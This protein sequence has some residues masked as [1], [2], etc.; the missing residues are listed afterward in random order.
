MKKLKIQHKG[1]GMRRFYAVIK[2]CRTLCGVVSYVYMY[3]N[4]HTVYI[5]KC[6]TKCFK[7]TQFHFLFYLKVS[8]LN[9]IFF[10]SRKAIDKT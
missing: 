2:N 5:G 6:T 9:G 8:E 4:I 3:I 1:I 10:F 7:S